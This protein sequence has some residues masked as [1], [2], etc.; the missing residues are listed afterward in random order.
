MFR[1]EQ[2]TKADDGNNSAKIM[3]DMFLK[4]FWLGR[5]LLWHFCQYKE[6]QNLGPE[7][8]THNITDVKN[9]N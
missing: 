8:W 7:K 3:R 4:L 2:S 5:M 9:A 1:P 6:I